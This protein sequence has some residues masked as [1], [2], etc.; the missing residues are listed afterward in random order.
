MKFRIEDTG[1]CRKIIHIDV[2]AEQVTQEYEEVLAMYARGARIP[3]FRPG[4]APR[5]LVKRH[6]AKDIDQEVKD[7]LVPSSYHSALEESKLDPVAILNVSDV[8]FKLGQPMQFSV[9]M[10]IPP[11]FELPS[12]VEIP[13]QRSR[14]EV[15]DKDV[16]EAVKNILEQRARWNDVSGRS[17]LKGDLVQI[18]FEGVC[19]GKPIDVLAPKAAGLARAKDY[20]MLV[21]EKSFLPG[22]AEGLVGANIGDK[23]QIFSDFAPDFQEPNLAGKKCTYFVDIKSIREKLVPAMDQEILK[24]LGVETEDD[25]R[26]RLREDLQKLGETRENRQLKNNIVKHLLEKTKL[27]VP[28]SVLQQETRETVY[29]MVRENSYRGVSREDIEGKK[30]EIFEAAN[31]TATERVKVRYILHRI[32]EKEKI[33]A[34]EEEISARIAEMARQYNVKPQELRADLD[35]RNALDGLVENIRGNK[36]LDFLLERAKVKQN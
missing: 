7:R 9:T 14:V 28:E 13:L 24:A 21:D 19:A 18:D 25:L 16:D 33:E 6:Y 20:W 36:T 27:D 35:K 17:V 3:G 26:K 2:P 11:A 22:F 1:P 32:A 8:E 31:R 10:D 34:S 15:A 12:Y 4:R 29:D 5:D 30:E 23:K